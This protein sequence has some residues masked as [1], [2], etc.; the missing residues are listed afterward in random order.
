VSSGPTPTAGSAGLESSQKAQSGLSRNAI[1]GIAVGVGGGVLVIAG[2]FLWLF[3]ARRRNKDTSNPHY[4]TQSYGSDVGVDMHGMMHD[5]EMPAVVESSRQSSGQGHYA[6]YS[7]RASTPPSPQHLEQHQQ[8]YQQMQTSSS[9]VVTSSQTELGGNAAAL[10]VTTTTSTYVHLVEEGMTP[11]E[12]RR[13]EEEE[14]QLDAEIESAGRRG[15][16]APS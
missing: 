9:P 8:H 6:P 3:C 11:E 2:V 4:P 14:R 13:L 10:P 1:I 5:K 16:S 12:I 15:L 7:D